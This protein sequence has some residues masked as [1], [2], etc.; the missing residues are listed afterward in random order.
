MAFRLH[1][2]LG[3]YHLKETEYYVFLLKYAESQGRL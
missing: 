2:K 1:R 3:W